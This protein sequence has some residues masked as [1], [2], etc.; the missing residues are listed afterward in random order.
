MDAIA[1]EA[2]VGKGTL[3]RAFGSREGLLDA[4]IE[5]KLAPVHMV[6]DIHRAD[7]GVSAPE[8]IVLLLDQLLIFKLE[9]R[10]LA[11]AR[12]IARP[13]ALRR[14]RYLA[15]F[16]RLEPLVREI[17]GTRPIADAVHVSHALLAAMHADILDE[18]IAAGRSTDE[19]RRAQSALVRS[20]LYQK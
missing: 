6:L 18:L 10:Y 20:V 16:A 19:I 2:G 5:A 9:N 14:A 13:G 3:F 7:S 1:S 17:L 15:E 8:R 11:R 12:E 4:L